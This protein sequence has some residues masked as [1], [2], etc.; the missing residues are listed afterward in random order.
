MIQLLTRTVGRLATMLLIALILSSSIAVASE[1]E[2]PPNVVVILVDDLGYM[3]VGANNPDC[4][5]DTPHIDGFAKTG[6]RFTNGYAANPYP[7]RVGA[8]NYFTG[9]SRGKF[10]GAKLHNRMPLDEITLAQTLKSK[11]YAT[12]FAGKWHLGPTEEYFPQNR[13]FDVNMGGWNKGGPY[14]GKRYFAPFENQRA[15]VFGL[16]FVLLRSHAVDGTSGSG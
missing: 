14:S 5:Y 9:N 4:F 11:G 8:T 7:T 2:T 16:P 13:G 1:P 15:T 10:A 6:L 12:F 3:D